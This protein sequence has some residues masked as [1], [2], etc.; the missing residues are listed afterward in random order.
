MNMAELI[1]R[2]DD[3]NTGREKL[4]NAILDAEDAKQKSVHAVN[5]SEQAKQIAQTAENKAD[6][7]Q[8][9]FNQV[10]IEGDSSV[11]AA[12]ARV[13]A[14]GRVFETLRD[15]L[16]YTDRQL[17]QNVE[18]IPLSTLN[19][20][21]DGKNNLNI[22][23]S[24]LTKNNIYFVVDGEYPL[25][26]DMIH[27]LDYDLNFVSFTNGVI[28]F[29]SPYSETFF[30]LKSNVRFRNVT[31]KNITDSNKFIFVTDEN[32]NSS[33]ETLTIEACEFVGNIR[34]ADLT[35][36]EQIKTI[37]F[38]H[39]TIKN[40]KI[41]F[42]QTSNF[43]I[44]QVFINNNNVQNWFYRLFSLTNFENIDYIEIANNFAT[45]TDD[46]VFNDIVPD[47]TYYV[48][49]LV[50]AKKIKYE[51]NTVENM[52]A[53][54]AVALYDCYAY[55]HEY[56]Y[57]NNTYRNNACFD[58]S[59]LGVLMK[60]KNEGSVKKFKDNTFII[61]DSFLA[62]WGV[63]PDNF[64]I[65]LYDIWGGDGVVEHTQPVAF[66]MY[67]NEITVPNLELETGYRYV[68]VF[69]FVGNVISTRN[70]YNSLVVS[71][72]G[73][74]KVKIT[75][76]EIKCESSDNFSIL[77]GRNDVI[78]KDFKF[79]NNFIKNVKYILEAVNV[80]YV[81]IHNNDIMNDLDSVNYLITYSICDVLTCLNN[82]LLNNTR[83]N[84]IHNT[85]IISKM[86][87]HNVGD[88]AGTYIYIDQLD[89]SK[90]KEINIIINHFD[91]VDKFTAKV[92][93]ENGTKKIEFTDRYGNLRTFDLLTSNGHGVD[94]K[95]MGDGDATLTFHNT[96][97]YSRLS[98]STNST[99]IVN[100]KY[101]IS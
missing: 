6:N 60:C 38:R 33:I 25:S 53:A 101:N 1:Q 54:T 94:V 66:Y 46:W 16:N 83:D 27:D 68:D 87:S 69:H 43:K 30:N 35:N 47:G 3:L 92:R 70:I 91:T 63:N 28:I 55:A 62:R 88:I 78:F 22:I 57:R 51:N 37:N 18:Y 90:E 80:K 9:Q 34:L 26:T 20:T 76:N 39:N 58:S 72:Q 40:T 50:K 24:K 42:F 100:I 75:D 71:K 13:T 45:N 2:T 49:A 8:E 5:V 36:C 15:R 82:R 74:A 17:A 29:N 21:D 81:M 12:Q 67:N 4:N 7:V 65:K 61:E 10:V 86:V 95:N 73:D 99:G 19:L 85:R 44:N 64:K 23:L 52:K 59:R 56:I 11:E 89:T 79:T 97:N 14:D 48:F 77:K 41:S 96:D 31:F 84:D 98:M 32:N 93:T